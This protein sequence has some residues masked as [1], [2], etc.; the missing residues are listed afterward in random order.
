MRERK[1]GKEERGK[2]RKTKIERKTE[3]RVKNL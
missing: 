1:W 2:Q 3:Q